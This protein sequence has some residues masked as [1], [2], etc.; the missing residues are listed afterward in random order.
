MIIWGTRCIQRPQ[1]DA[2]ISCGVRQLKG[3]GIK[4]G[5]RVALSAPTSAEYVVLL[6]S[7][8][9]MKAVACPVDPHWPQK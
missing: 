5:E 2:Y 4:A 9:R 3:M 8:W 6:L 1:L 7:L